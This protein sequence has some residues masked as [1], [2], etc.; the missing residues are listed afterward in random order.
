[1]KY[2]SASWVEN[3]LLGQSMKT[4][5]PIRRLKMIL[6]LGSISNGMEEK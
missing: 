2:A 3:E 6:G 4:G 5:S 1:M